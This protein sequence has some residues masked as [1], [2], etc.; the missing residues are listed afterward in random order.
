MKKKF[1]FAILA[2]NH[3]Q[4]IFDHLESIKYQIKKYG[5]G[6]TFKLV[7]GDDGSKDDTVDKIKY[8]L[9]QHYDLFSEV[10][11]SGD[12][13]NR[14]TCIN[15]TNMW[16]FID[17]DYFKIT[18][19]DDVYSFENV[20]NVASLLDESDYISGIPLLLID[21]KLSFSKT[22]AFNIFATNKIYYT[23]S[24]RSRIVG[25]NV[26][27]TPSQ[28]YSK[29][30]LN[31][32]TKEFICKFKVTEDFP[33]VTK[34]AE[35]YQNVKYHQLN[36][37]LIYYRRTNGSIYL[38]RSEE[39]NSDKEKV[40]NELLSQEKSKW[41]E[42]LL[43]NRIWCYSQK[44]VY[45]KLIFNLNYYVYFFRV[46]SNLSSILKEYGK[47]NVKLENHQ[48]YLNQ[49]HLRTQNHEKIYKDGVSC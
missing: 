24:F 19:G 26:M 28:Y 36:K 34:I 5:E 32:K 44:K 33:M 30:F 10:V 13:I 37:V 21:E 25:I 35:D 20:I 46:L 48:A 41:G 4:Y 39:F 49:I 1:V 43:K 42:L 3:S 29:K 27:N 9:K 18:A 14:G 38:S 7:V 8:W 47:F 6:Y 31:K 45:I 40:F 15:Y 16:E 22:L 12:G 2:Y 17:S 11:F 23:K